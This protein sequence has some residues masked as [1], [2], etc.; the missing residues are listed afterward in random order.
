[1]TVL[2]IELINPGAR[3]LLEDLAKLD[4]IR[5]Q[6]VEEVPQQLSA[7][8]ARLRSH[9]ADVPTLDEITQEVEE[10]RHQRQ[11]SNG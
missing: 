5:I 11:G 8:L 3:V 6:E 9:E 7:L 10:V 2:K 1:M 4:L